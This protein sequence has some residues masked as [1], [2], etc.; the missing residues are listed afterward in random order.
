ME[1]LPWLCSLA[2]RLLF[3]V[4]LIRRA[5]VK[6]L[7]WTFCIVEVEI[8]S[9]QL[10]GISNA[11]V[12]AQINLFV[13]HTASK[14]HDKRIISPGVFAVHADRDFG[15]EQQAGEVEAGSDVVWFN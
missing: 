10:A 4:N 15:I 13:F 7:V 5:A 9:N 3:E 1:C 14:P 2:E 12:G 11:F 6:A 8:T